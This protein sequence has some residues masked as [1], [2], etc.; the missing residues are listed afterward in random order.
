MYNNIEIII[1]SIV[2]GLLIGLERERS[3][4]VGQQA[5][6]VRT[7]I[8]FALLGTIAAFINQLILTV[9]LSVFVFGA[10]LLSYLRSTQQSRSNK[11]DIGITTEIAA[12]IVFCLGYIA[13]HNPLLASI[14]GAIVLLVLLQRKWLH[15]FSRSKL[16]SK[17]IKAA[18]VLAIF[19]LGLLPLL[20][21]HVIDPWQI[22]NPRRFGILIAAIAWIQFCGYVAIRVFGQRLGIMLLGFFGGLISSTAV[23]ASLPR[24]VLA[25]TELLRPAVMAGILAT[26][27]M[28]LELTIILFI[29]SPILLTHVIWLMV[30]MAITGLIATTVTLKKDTTKSAFPYIGNPL[31][32]RSILKLSLFIGGMI[33]FAA[34]VNFYIGSKGIN[35]IAVL[36]GLFEIHGTCLAVATLFVNGKLSLFD[37]EIAIALAI[38]SSFITK[39]VLLWTLTRDRFAL[40][41]SL[42]LLTMMLAGGITFMMIVR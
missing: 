8:L 15:Q 3:H 23:F 25:Q 6:G 28:L 31:D 22:F 16:Q 26:V 9:A 19:T 36:G 34:L 24:I 12:G 27:A 39:F 29:V 35:F 37:A 21:N 5:V 2:I 4:P 11:I 41:T 30:V 7:F 13:F 20:P 18:V 40:I 1:V 42:L 38:M 17:E 10:I 14:L 32:V 33:F